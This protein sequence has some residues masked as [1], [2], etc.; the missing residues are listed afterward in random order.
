MP[1]PLHRLTVPREHRP[2]RM[3]DVARRAGVSRALVSIVLNGKPGASPTT[4]ERV[5]A[6]AAELGYTPDLNAR[7]LR[8]GTTALIGVIFEGHDAFTACVLDAA[9]DAAARRGLDLVLTMSSATVPLSRAVHTLTRQRVRGILLISSAA[10][11]AEAVSLLA[12]VPCAVVGAYAPTALEGR[13]FSVHTDD[14]SAMRQVVRHLA[15]QGYRHL[16]V[17]RVV[18]RRSGDVRAGAAAEEA[19]ALGLEVTEVSVGGYDESDGVR[20]GAD[21]LLALGPTSGGL[22]RPTAVVGANDALALGILHVLRAAD[23]RVPQDVGLTGFDDAKAG[24]SPAG[25]LGLTT[26]HQ[27]AVGIV[28]AALAALESGGVPHERVLPGR[29]VLRR[30]TAP[31]GP[32]APVTGTNATRPTGS[33]GSTDPARVSGAPVPPSTSSQS[34]PPPHPAGWTRSGQGTNKV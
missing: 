21:V 23:L 13:V 27:D 19:A 18:G 24:H 32:P 17:T 7:R 25:A 12:Q 3:I 33:T 10:P 31:T 29:L 4:R 20:A 16:V 26:V 34:P 8:A 28:Q 14:A 1:P 5:L 6:A 22:R 9:H 11:D 15:G 2:P 30:T